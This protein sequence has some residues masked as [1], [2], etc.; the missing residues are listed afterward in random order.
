MLSSAR[1]TPASPLKKRVGIK[2][3]LDSDQL[4]EI[5]EAFQLFDTGH[6]NQLDHRELKAAI[7]ALGFEANKKYIRQVYNELSK[8]L[9][10]PISYEEFLAI[11]EPQ[12]K[13]RDPR[14]ETLKLFRMFDDDNTG[15]LTFKNL[16]RIANELG[17]ALTDPEI[18]EMIEEVD[19]EGDGSITFDDFFR[20][21]SKKEGSLDVFS[22][23]D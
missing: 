3:Y 6:N 11:I 20:V 5:K 21:M 12:V 22:D 15:R 18:Q 1:K 19:R 23:E 10:Q 14:E 2:T 13:S 16:R 9:S 17:E 7:R 8:D 4:A